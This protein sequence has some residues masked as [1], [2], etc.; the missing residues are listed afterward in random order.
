MVHYYFNS[1]ALGKSACGDYGNFYYY[2]MT[3]VL[4]FY[5]YFI[6]P[7]ICTLFFFKLLFVKKGGVNLCYE[8]LNTYATSIQRVY[9][10]YCLFLL[11]I[12]F[13]SSYPTVI[14][15]RNGKPIE[16][17]CLPINRIDL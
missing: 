12:L 11:S 8:A 15:E 1:Q 3:S 4:Y 10:F 17:L 9:F 6:I 5:S 13:L 16:L 7:P 14:Y 2:S